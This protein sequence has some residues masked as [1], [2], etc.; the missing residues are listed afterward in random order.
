MEFVRVEKQ[1]AVAVVTLRHEEQNR[2]TTPFLREILDALAELERDEV[3]RAVVVAT[4]QEK[5][6]SSGLHLEWMMV[7]GA[8]G[9]AVL[10]E[11]M[12]MLHRLLVTAT[13]YPKPLVGAIG[14]HAVGAG[15]VFAAC[16]DFRLMPLDRGFIRFPEVQVSI[17]FWPGMMALIKD[18][19]PAASLRDFVYTGKPFPSAR[20]KEMGFV[21]ELCPREG[22]VARAVELAAELATGDLATY[23]LIKRELRR[24]VLDTMER[25]DP[26]AIAALVAGMAKAYGV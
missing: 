10:K 4:G 22:L 12:Q 24:G 23:G 20:A 19:L 1:G 15:A 6:F 26:R 18:I 17:P 9:P 16:L 7:Q 5:H 8:K 2:F 14:G 11:F 21:D 25:E 13:A 3:V